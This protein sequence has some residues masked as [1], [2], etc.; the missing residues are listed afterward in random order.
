MSACPSD[1][2]MAA[3]ADGHLDAAAEQ[4]LHE[5]VDTCDACQ[6][7][8]K[9]LATTARRSPE[10]ADAPAP[11]PAEMPTPIEITSGRPPPR[12]YGVGD[13]LDGR[14]RLERHLGSGGMGA[15]WAAR[16]LGTNRPVA[17]KILRGDLRSSAEA[18]QRFQLEARVLSGIEHPNLVPVR[19]LFDDHGAPVLAMD[20]LV[21]ESL[22]ERL[23]RGGRIELGKVARLI[24]GALAAIQTAHEDGVIHR[25]LKP[26]NFYL[27][28][29]AGGDETLLVLDFGI[30]KLV[31]ENPEQVAI[32]G[33]GEVLGTPPYMA[34]EQ[35]RG[36]S[37]LDRRV[38]VW[39]LGVILYECLSGRRPFTGERF[40][41][42]HER[43]TRGE[44]DPISEAAPDLPRDVIALIERMLTVDRDA[45]CPDL[46]EAIDV[47]G[48]H[49]ATD[50]RAVP[51]RRRVGPR[52][53]AAVGLVA[54]LLAGAAVVRRP[55]SVEAR[56]LRGDGG[57][58]VANA[59]LPPPPGPSRAVVAASSTPSETPPSAGAAPSPCE[60]EWGEA[61][62]TWLC[63]SPQLVMREAAYRVWR[64]LRLEEATEEERTVLA[65]ERKAVGWD[66]NACGGAEPCLLRRL[67]AI[68]PGIGVV[69]CGRAVSSDAS[70]ICQDAGL[71]TLAGAVA[72]YYRA[73][74]DHYALHHRRLRRLPSGQTGVIDP[75][76]GRPQIVPTLARL[77][78]EQTA[79]LV[80]R[81]RCGDSR[82]CLLQSLETRIGALRAIHRAFVVELAPAR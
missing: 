22:G 8:L 75:R 45:R 12:F 21:G 16:H 40:A 44:R 18:R 42:F 60:V 1:E 43:V 25:D 69:D 54:V 61:L 76:G 32:T 4:A 64:D 15:V 34:P 65:H 27:V 24:G 82:A 39:A 48:R 49:A 13:V 71:A 62:S 38:D 7:L 59:T 23:S 52:A 81:H 14:Y 66:L 28:S 20:L 58:T 56:R 78:A 26:D 3:F 77:S 36:E 57:A 51:V 6:W 67:K 80:E 70:A 17:L 74:R 46:R 9:E 37:D 41:Q 11:D 30:A 55:W 5:H 10:P 68:A 35:L 19:D 33:K 47:M 29:G 63:R 31:E 72:A 53:M 50:D 73:D 2:V 79:W